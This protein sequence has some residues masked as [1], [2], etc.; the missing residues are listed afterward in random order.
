MAFFIGDCSL[1]EALATTA[2][3]SEGGETDWISRQKLQAEIIAKAQSNTPAVLALMSLA[4]KGLI[5]TEKSLLRLSGEPRTPFVEVDLFEGNNLPVVI[6]EVLSVLDKPD[7]EYS[8]LSKYVQNQVDLASGVGRLRT[9]LEQL[10]TWGRADFDDPTYAQLFGITIADL[11]R[12]EDGLKSHDGEKHGSTGGW[13]SALAGFVPLAEEVLWLNFS[14]FYSKRTMSAVAEA[15]GRHLQSRNNNMTIKIGA[16]IPVTPGIDIGLGAT[17]ATEDS[18]TLSSLYELGTKDTAAAGVKF[19]TIC[20]EL[21]AGVSASTAAAQVFYNLSTM[22]DSGALSKIAN[23]DKLT[24]LANALEDRADMQ[25]KQEE[26]LAKSDKL[27]G[28][29][30]LFQ[31]IAQNGTRVRWIDVTESSAQT[32][33][34]ELTLAASAEA[35][36]SAVAAELGAEIKYST[37]VKRHFS[38]FPV[39]SWVNDLLILVNLSLDDAR[40]LIGNKYDLSSKLPNLSI[41]KGHLCSYIAVVAE[42]DEDRNQLNELKGKTGGAKSKK[43]LTNKIDKSRNKKRELEKLLC[44]SGRGRGDVVKSVLLTSI[45]LRDNLEKNSGTASD[46]DGICQDIYYELCRLCQLQRFSKKTTLFGGTNRPT[47]E[48]VVKSRSSKTELK[49]QL[50][51]PV[52]GTINT[53]FGYEQVKNSP[54]FHENGDFLVVEYEMPWG[55]LGFKYVHHVHQLILKATRSLPGDFRRLSEDVLLTA[56]NATAEKTAELFNFHEDPAVLASL[57][58]ASDTTSETPENKSAQGV[59][60]KLTAAIDTTSTT[61]TNKI[62]FRERVLDGRVYYV[63]DHFRTTVSSDSAT[64]LSGPRFD[65][66]EQSETSD[67]N[68]NSRPE[69]LVRAEEFVAD[70]ESSLAQSM[71]GATPIL[72][73]VSGGWNTK[74]GRVVTVLGDD[75]MMPYCRKLSAL[76]LGNENSENEPQIAIFLESQKDSLS[77][78]FRNIATPGTNASNEL[79]ECSDTLGTDSGAAQHFSELCQGLSASP[80]TLA[81]T[82]DAFLAMCRA[83][84]K[85][86][87]RPFYYAAFHKQAAQ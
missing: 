11:K 18:P 52:F 70:R 55:A 59:I 58:A 73:H 46:Y 84:Y 27:E 26:L 56:L 72:K 13:I 62:V 63:L 64:A 65:A 75:T 43:A 8:Q 29:L 68:T 81:P 45:V 10:K 47:W 17:H 34:K 74:K 24:I 57:K 78:L 5:A 16:K 19:S 35:T 69:L 30:K 85:R 7:A 12:V 39:M 40:R 54:F 49:V 37:S 51:V 66:S 82:T 61:S 25:T 32:K 60:A 22:A 15:T 83:A 38:D 53:V 33:T 28:Y 87:Y 1:L 31:V 86:T 76:L 21:G 20:V 77:K 6:L 48:G 23:S 44:P 3:E 80:N 79:K 4:N 14:Q 67:S 50:T 42:L 36:L 71:G 9:D 41:V 2:E